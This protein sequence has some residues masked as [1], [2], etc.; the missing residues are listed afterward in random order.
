M[1]LMQSSGADL[2]RG[3]IVN[4][5][6]GTDS[7]LDRKFWVALVLYAV[8]AVLVWFTMSGDK[9]FVFNRWV[10]LRLVPLIVIGALAL[11]TVVARQ[12]GNTRR[13]GESDS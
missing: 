9:V 5:Q 3:R 6:H 7:E 2:A 4:G 13:R 11:R 1:R 10:D 12:A 8:L